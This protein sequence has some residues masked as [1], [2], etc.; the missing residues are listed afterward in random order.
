MIAR[1]TTNAAICAVLFVIA[2]AEVAS[3]QTSEEIAAQYKLGLQACA[4]KFPTNIPQT[5][6]VKV[7]CE[8]RALAILLPNWGTNGDL[9]QTWIADRLVIAERI[10]NKKMTVAEGLA[11]MAQRWSET[12]TEIQ[13]RNAYAA[14]AD[15][16]RAAAQSNAVPQQNAADRANSA[17]AQTWV[18]IFQ[19]LRPTPAPSPAQQNVRV[20]ST[21]MHSGNFTFCN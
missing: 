7:Q 3:A 15:A 1:K 4:N 14:Q 10:Q 2:G 18:N 8:N 11:A 5:I 17:D 16:A 20:Q 19:A 6:V 9:L 13:R 12:K 21:C